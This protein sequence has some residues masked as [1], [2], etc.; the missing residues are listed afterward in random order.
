MDSLLHVPTLLFV[1]VVASVVVAGG[2][3]VVGASHRREGLG[4]WAFGLFMH[5]LAYVLVMGRGKLPDLLSIVLSNTL[6]SAVFACLLGGMYQFL[7]R[8]LPWRW[9]IP[10][11]LATGV[12]FTVYLQSYPARLIVSGI[13]FPLQLLLPVALLWRSDAFRHGRGAWLVFL[14]LVLQAVV[15]VLRAVLVA[16]G[17]LP[18]QGVMHG[19]IVQYLIFLLA[20]IT[21]QASS[22]GFVLMAIERADAANRR[23][24][25]QDPLTGVANRRATI[26]ALE[27]GVAQSVHTGQP[28][29]LLM[30]DIDH[31]KRVNDDLGHLAGDRVLCGVVDVLCGRLR[32]QDFIGRYG[33][34][35]FLV[36]LPRTPLAG[37]L[38]LARQ[39]C[40]AVEQA[41][42]EVGNSE[43]PVTISVGVVSCRLRPGD[44]WECLIDSADAAMYRA[45]RS[46]RNRV[47]SAESDC[48]PAAALA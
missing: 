33:G 23:L 40:V 11:V 29:A 24:A 1:T 13:V 12:L 5:A 9:M 37:A 32:A 17:L 25:S 42:I 4:L 16:M 14:T 21:V 22:F 18:G 6:V 28:L 19:D 7:G 46:G 34:E 43:L 45:K 41:H 10:P 8:P 15:L 44:R 2:L 36:L 31:F 27:G 39:L 38:E 30:V 26:A 20:F 47:E 35:E 3:L 48:I